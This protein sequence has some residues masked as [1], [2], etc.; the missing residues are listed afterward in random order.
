[1]KQNS[2]QISLE[3][4]FKK[5]TLTGMGA[6]EGV[7]VFNIISSYVTNNPEIITFYLSIGNEIFD[8][9]FAREAI[10]KLAK[11]FRM[12]RGVCLVNIVNE[13]VIDNIL[14]PV[15][16]LDQPVPFYQDG[17]LHHV[18]FN[19]IGTPSKTNQKIFEFIATRDLTTANEIVDKF[20]LKLSN[21]STKLKSLFE[22]GFILRKEQK[23]SSG[24]IEYFYFAIK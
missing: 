15:L 4:I 17:A 13:D 6:E 18:G 7:K 9:S 22:E 10:V 5:H 8:A 2:N 12:K 21:A 19:K 20:Q 16:R 14:G 3:E 1:M 11:S 23:S 24:G